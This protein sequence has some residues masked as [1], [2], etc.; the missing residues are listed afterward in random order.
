MKNQKKK[1]KFKDIIIIPKEIS[2]L[3][4]HFLLAYDIKKA[5]IFSP[6][7]LFSICSL[8]S[9]AKEKHDKLGIQSAR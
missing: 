3:F 4:L 1:A 2:I 6:F 7:Y 5:V 9:S 8:F